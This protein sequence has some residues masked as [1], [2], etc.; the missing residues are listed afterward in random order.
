MSVTTSS[1]QSLRD[2]ADGLDETAVYY[3]GQARRIAEVLIDDPESLAIIADAVRVYADDLHRRVRRAD[4][5]RERAIAQG[6]TP[7]E[8]GMT[9]EIREQSRR[10]AT[11][12]IVGLVRDLQTQS[13][14]AE[15]YR[16]QAA[17]HEAAADEGEVIA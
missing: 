11:E 2:K 1:T 15:W 14:L 3:E 13:Y 8:H 16:D 9:T 12:G 4:E 6:R 5:R 17:S 10:I 7:S